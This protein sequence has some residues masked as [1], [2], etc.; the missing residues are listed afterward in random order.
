MPFSIAEV[1]DD[2]DFAQSFTI[3]R[4]QG[5]KFVLGRW[6]NA[7]VDIPM[8]GSIQPPDPEE[9]E[10]IPEGDRIVAAIAVHCTQRIYETN[11]NQTNGISDLVLWHGENY[12]VLKVYPWNDYGYWKA[13]AA[14]ISGQ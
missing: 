5:G 14:R 10:M 13:I 12:R 11:T 7:T 6:T 8:W 4:S 1:V 2:P 3:T 9:L